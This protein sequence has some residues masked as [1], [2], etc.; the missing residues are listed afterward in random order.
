LAQEAT[1]FG[2]VTDPS[3]AAVSNVAI[4]ITNTDAGLVTHASSNEV[5]VR[6]T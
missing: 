2:T 6:G 1:I 5:G 3:G 4:T